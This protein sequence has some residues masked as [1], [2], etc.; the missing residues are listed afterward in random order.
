MKTAIAL[1]TFDGLHAGHCAVLKATDTFFSVA[2]TFNIPPKCVTSGNNELLMLPDDRA[3][4][5]KQLGINRVVMQNFN[6]VKDIEPVD[7]LEMLNRDYNPTRIVC[8]FNYR[9]GKDALGDV[10]ML[11]QFCAK[12]NI[13]FIC[14][15]PVKQHGE[16]VSSTNIRN[17]IREGN[18]EQAASQIYGG[19]RFTAPVLH[20]DRRGRTIGFPTANQNYPE[21]LVKPRFGVYI[22]RVAIDGKKYNAITNIGI[23]PTYKTDVVGCESY[24]KDFSGDIYGKNMKTQI[25]RFIREE[26]K[27]SSLNQLKAA[28]SNDIRH[29]D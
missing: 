29:L 5:I 12:H 11:K 4:R 7:Y 3:C 2:I 15:P 16:I 23:R 27:F 6:T 25:V 18:V 17:L 24:I 19:F 21:D 26:Q 28:I 10:E 9:F 1:G 14:V 8:G 13:E 22:T 20:G